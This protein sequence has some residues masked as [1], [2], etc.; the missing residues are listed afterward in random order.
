MIEIK[1]PIYVISKGRY[2]KCLTADFLLTDGV[3]FKLVVEPQEKN[4]YA[5]K[6]GSDRVLVLPFSNL[7]LG[8][9]PARNWCWEN[10]IQNGHDK[11]WILDDNIRQVWRWNKGKK[12]SPESRK[13]LSNSCKGRVPWNKGIPHSTET[14]KKIGELA[15]KRIRERNPLTGQFI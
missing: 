8:S 3:D 10:S 1:Y 11:H 7:G 9:I 4:L 12:M 13:K 5:D 6:F 2:E 15:S 14:K